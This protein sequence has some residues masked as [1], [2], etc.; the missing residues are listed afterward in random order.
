MASQTVTQAG[1]QPITPSGALNT[2]PQ[3]GQKPF[4][5]AER[6]ALVLRALGEDV[7]AAALRHLDEVTIARISA[8]MTALPPT[9]PDQMR[10]VMDDFAYD[11][12][13]GGGVGSS[14]GLRFITNVLSAALGKAH[15]S[16]ILETAIRGDRTSPFNLPLNADPRTL[17][18]QMANE[19]PQTIALLLAHIPHDTGAAMLSFLPEALA[20]DALYRFTMLDAVAPGAILELKEMLTELM[21]QSGGGGRRLANLGGA[22]QT[23]DILNHLQT[24]LSDQVL[25]SIEERDRDTADKIRENLFT[26]LD[27]GKLTDRTL[28]LLLRD[29]PSDRLAPALRLVDENVRVRFY[30]NIS[31]RMAEVLKEELRSGPPMRRSD[32]LA[33]Q[34][35]IVSIALRLASEGKITISASEEMI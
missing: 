12:G 21:A 34:N 31:A 30:N 20:A 9:S 13:I 27:L 16:A 25:K 7:A 32:A 10:Q 6:A 18:M 26:F 33:A 17:A 35:E 29:V 11:L 8:A 19:R 22:R 14:D 15:A 23:A 5:G 28:Q 2:P 24:G 1:A 4:K 3:S